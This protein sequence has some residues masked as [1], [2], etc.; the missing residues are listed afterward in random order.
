MSLCLGSG[1]GC[2]SQHTLSGW[3][4]FKG[5]VQSQICQLD[6][7]SCASSREVL[8]KL[9]FGREISRKLHGEPTA[10][11]ASVLDFQTL[12]HRLSLSGLASFGTVNEIRP[13]TVSSTTELTP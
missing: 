11:P 4:G 5:H 13:S 2:V 10:S 12:P 3:G 6:E 7:G 1:D 8:Q 9:E